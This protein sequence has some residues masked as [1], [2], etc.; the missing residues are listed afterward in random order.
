MDGMLA[1][2]SWVTWASPGAEKRRRIWIGVG[3]TLNPG[4]ERAGAESEGEAQASDGAEI[5]AQAQ[6]LHRLGAVGRRRG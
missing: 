5:E 6:D 4:F 2:A 3:R 1:V